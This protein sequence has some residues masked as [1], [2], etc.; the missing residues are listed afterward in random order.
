MAML[1][2]VAATTRPTTRRCLSLDVISILLPT[3]AA[4][5]VL[6]YLVG[7]SLSRRPPASRR[8]SD[9]DLCGGRLRVWRSVSEIGNFS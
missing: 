8:G 6:E 1:S 3:G 7:A 5:G 4:S 9:H 2:A